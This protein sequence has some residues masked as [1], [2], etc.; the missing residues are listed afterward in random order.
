MVHCHSTNTDSVVATLKPF[1]M[2]KN[3]FELLYS[4]GGRN[5]K[6]LVLSACAEMQTL[7]L[8]LMLESPLE[9]FTK[10]FGIMWSCLSFQRNLQKILSS[11]K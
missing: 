7:M 11:C 8:S 1:L 2:Q 9:T 4:Q 10:Y 3:L 5:A 6:T